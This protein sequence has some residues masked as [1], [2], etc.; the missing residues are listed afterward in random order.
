MKSVVVVMGV[1]GCGKSSAGSLLAQRL[2]IRFVEGDNLHPQANVDKMRAGMP[3]DDDDRKPWLERVGK[4]LADAGEDGGVVVACSALKKRYRD[5][6][7]DRAGPELRFIH[8]TGDRAVL[9]ARMVNR[10]GHYMPVSLL[11]SQLA[12]LEA[13]YGEQD[14]LEV[15]CAMEQGLIIET[16]LAFLNATE[17]ADNE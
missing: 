5:L 17:G 2:G 16:S 4:A 9:A 7:R 8:L 1:S 12:T 6:L 11:D 13:T 14:V 3:L 15:D 10:P